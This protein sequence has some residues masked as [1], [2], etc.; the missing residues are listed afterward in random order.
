[1][2][3]SGKK[4]RTMIRIECRKEEKLRRAM[5]V[6]LARSGAADGPDVLRG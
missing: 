4:K 5:L 3:V 6:A 1:M 2:R